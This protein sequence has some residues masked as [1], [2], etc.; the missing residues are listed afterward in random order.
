MTD[1][2]GRRWQAKIITTFATRSSGDDG[3]LGDTKGVNSD[4]LGDEEFAEAMRPVRLEVRGPDQAVEFTNLDD[5]D[6]EAYRLARRKEREGRQMR[7][8]APGRIEE[9]SSSPP[10]KPA[11]GQWSWQLEPIDT[12][13][14]PEAPET[15]AQ[16]IGSEERAWVELGSVTGL[17]S[18]KFSSNVRLVIAQEHSSGIALQSAPHIAS[19][20]GVVVLVDGWGHTPGRRD[21]LSTCKLESRTT[22]DSLVRRVATPSPFPVL[23]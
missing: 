16:K 10:A 9:F 5:A 21:V 1:E 17:R 4:E 2:E 8:L 3:S 20:L 12:M 6:V 14:L 23:G 7:Q 19:T 11:N 22:Q 13:R 15:L 18:H